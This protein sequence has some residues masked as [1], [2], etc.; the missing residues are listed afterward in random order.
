M[1][2]EA[3]QNGSVPVDEEPC[4]EVKVNNKRKAY[5]YADMGE[6]SQNAVV[7][8]LLTGKNKI[9]AGLISRLFFESKII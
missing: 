9:K 4:V 1:S 6:K 7:Q 5:A 8:P 2:D 3:N